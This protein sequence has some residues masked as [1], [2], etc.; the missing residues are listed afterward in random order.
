LGGRRT[1]GN[2][3]DPVGATTGIV[4][5]NTVSPF[6]IS[7]TIIKN[8]SQF[9]LY[10]FGTENNISQNRIT[11]NGVPWLRGYGQATVFGTN[12]YGTYSDNYTAFNRG[13]VQVQG[14]N[15]AAP[16]VPAVISNNTIE[17]VES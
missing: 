17:N 4:T 2:E 13:G 16:G 9:P 11:N 7:N 14:H 15:T 3:V 12:A 5:D 1:S 8:T 6:T 10:V